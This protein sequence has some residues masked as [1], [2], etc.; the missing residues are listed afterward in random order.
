MLQPIDTAHKQ[1]KAHLFNLKFNIV[2]FLFYINFSFLSLK[3]LVSKVIY[4]P[5]SCNL[6]KNL[7]NKADAICTSFPFFL[8]GK[9]E[10]RDAIT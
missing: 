8:L 2:F 9:M 10:Y 5:S 7:K 1:D 3:Y 6:V 4:Q